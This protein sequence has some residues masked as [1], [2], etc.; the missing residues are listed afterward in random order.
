MPVWRRGN[1]EALVMRRSLGRCD[2]H[3][4]F[5][6]SDTKK[7]LVNQSVAVEDMAGHCSWTAYDRVALYTLLNNTSISLIRKIK[8]EV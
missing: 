3:L 8:L 2:F 7:W 1:A 4:L 6:I 5:K